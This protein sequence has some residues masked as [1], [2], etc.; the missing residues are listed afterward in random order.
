MGK[1][2]SIQRSNAAEASD[3]DNDSHMSRSDTR[4]SIIF[5]RSVQ[6]RDSHTTSISLDMTSPW[7]VREITPELTTFSG[8]FDRFGVF[9]IGAR[10]TAVKLAAGSLLLFSPIPWSG[11]VEAALEK[12]SGTKPAK[13]AYLVAPDR[14]HYLQIKDYSA[15][16]PEAKVIGVEELPAKLDG[17]TFHKVF[18]DKKYE[19]VR[20]GFEDEIDTVYVPGHL[21]KELV[22]VH[23]KTRTLIEAD[24]LFNLPA[25]EQYRGSSSSAGVLGFLSP[26]RHLKADS[27]AHRWFNQN[28][29]CKDKPSFA[30]SMRE[31]AKLDFDRLIPC[32][33]ETIDTGA[34][35]VFEQAFAPFLG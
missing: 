24:L 7:T 34:K 18:G 2:R 33:G 12:L 16:F 29:A 28:M 35:Q 23:K 31:I 27:G 3:E 15:R 19:G 17:I 9:K 8:P 25:F 20:C 30:A 13:V 22:L 4:S 21:N 26:F 14:E 32:H 10:A 5:Q 11:E 6:D 1:F